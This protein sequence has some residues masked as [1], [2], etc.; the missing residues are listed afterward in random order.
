MRFFKNKADNRFL[1]VGLGNPGKQ[2]KLTRHN[3]GF[4]ALDFIA[5]DFGI[6]VTRSRF[7]ALTGEGRVCGVNVTLLKPLTYMNLSGQAVLAASKYYNISPDRVVVI[8][9]DVA[10]IP[11]VI[12]IRAQGS[13]GGQKGLLSIEDMLETS[14]F[15]RL[16]IGVGQPN[17]GQ[18]KDYVLSFPT[19]KET[20]LIKG[21]FSDI[22]SAVKLIIEGKLSEAQSLYNGGI[23]T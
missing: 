16:R 5:N 17:L 2:Y 13:S 22:S 10:L 14:Q 20:E 18:I 11:G 15:T 19:S 3:I 9:D 4:E 7:S 1:V 6:R 21:R 23:Q 12:R 8:C